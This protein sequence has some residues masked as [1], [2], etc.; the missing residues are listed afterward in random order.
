M[1]YTTKVPKPLRSALIMATA[2]S[3]MV[4]AFSAGP[5]GAHFPSMQGTTATNPNGGS[6]G[7]TV[8]VSAAGAQAGSQYTLMFADP[9]QVQGFEQGGGKE[10]HKEAC[11]HAS[12]INGPYT[13]DAN[14]TISPVSVT[15]PPSSPGRALICFENPNSL[16]KPVEFTVE[17][18][19]YMPGSPG[20]PQR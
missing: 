14:G 15:V 16:T 3:G 12:P 9:S 18:N 17:G 6:P 8:Q 13:P 7:S 1:R 4:L 20:S 5:V 10:G 2:A 19:M 11:A